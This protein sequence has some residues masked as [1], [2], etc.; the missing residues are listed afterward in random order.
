MQ[1]LW[2]DDLDEHLFRVPIQPSEA[3]PVL[4]DFLETHWQ[5]S[6]HHFQP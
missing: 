1:L 4:Q 5:G 2:A 6:S 3:T